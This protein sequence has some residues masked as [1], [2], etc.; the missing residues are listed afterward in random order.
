METV[1]W[2]RRRIGELEAENAELRKFKESMTGMWVSVFSEMGSAMGMPISTSQTVAPITTPQTYP[3]PFI[4]NPSAA[5]PQVV[6][7]FHHPQQPVTQEIPPPSAEDQ[8]PI[9]ASQYHLPITSANP[10]PANHVPV[11]TP[12]TSTSEN[13][14]NTSEVTAVNPTRS[15]THHGPTPNKGSI[16]TAFANTSWGGHC[17][18]NPD[19]NPAFKKFSDL[20]QDCEKETDFLDPEKLDEGF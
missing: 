16:D 3:I 1:E 13:P 14:L 8:P 7:G 2:S 6:P 12:S 19:A 4:V 15:A 5:L 10:A 18:D 9:T 11:L 17:D 20:D